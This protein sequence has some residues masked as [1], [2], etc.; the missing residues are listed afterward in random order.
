MTTR[1]LVLTNC[2]CDC[3]IRDHGTGCCFVDSCPCTGRVEE[4]EAAHDMS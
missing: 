1:Y 4:V 2:T 3:H